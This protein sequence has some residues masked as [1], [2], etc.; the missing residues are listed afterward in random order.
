M[1]CLFPGADG[2]SSYWA[3]IRNRVDAIT[4][5]PPSHWR[6]DDYHDPD[7]RA[8]DRVYT[9]RGGFLSPVPFNPAAFGIAPKDLEAI[10]TAQLL[11]LVVAQQALADAGVGVD[12]SRTAVI[13]GVTGTLELVI[14]LGAR[15]GH[16]RWRRALREAGVA[17][18]VA[19]DVVRRIGDS[20]VGWQENS[21]PGLL[22]N[23]VA[24]RIANRFDL[25]GTNCVVDAACASSLSA[26]H[27][28]ALE[29]ATRRA[30]V[31]LT[32]GVDTFND[33]FMYMCFSKT[34]A[35]S[36]TGDARPFDAG[37]DGTILGEGLG[38]VVL[39]RL[40]DA[41]RDGDRIYAIV[42]GIGT[43]SD[44]K[45][46][47]VYAP[48][49]AG[50][51][52]ALRRA[53][54]SADISPA[55][56]ELIE[57][58]GTGTRVGDAT[59]VAALSEVYRQCGREGSWCALGSVKSQIGHTKAAAGIAG[60]L[61]A[62]AALHHKVLPPTIKVSRP[63]ENLAGGRS[64][65]YVNTENRPWMPAP[66]H[67]RRAAVSAFGFGGSNYHCVL[68]EASPT[69]ECVDWDGDVQILAFSADHPM[70]VREQFERWSADIAW[71]ELRVRAAEL[72]RAWRADRPCR[73]TIVVQRGHTDLTKVIPTIREGLLRQAEWKTPEGVYHA[74]GPEKGRLAVLFPGQGSQYVGMLRDLACTFPAM[75]DVLAE[76]NR[77]EN[78]LTDRIY[79][80]SRFTPEDRHADED[81]LRAT[82]TAQPALGAVSLGAWRVLE[83]FGVRADAMAGHSFGELTALCAAGRLTTGELHTLSRLRGR[84]M[85]TAGAGSDAGSMLAV[86]ATLEDIFRILREERLD[87]ALANKNGPMQ[88]VLSGSTPDIE[89]AAAVFAARKIQAQRLPVSAAF[90]SPLVAG[91]RQPLHDALANVAF[92]RG[93]VAVYADSTA[94]VYPDDAVAARALLAEQLARPVEFADLIEHLHRDGV[95][96]F[97]EVGPGAR[98]AGLV[99][100]ILGGQDHAALALDSSSG[101]RGGMYDL[102]RVLAW[103]AAQ[104]HSVRLDLWDPRTPP[105]SPA[106]E[107]R[108]PALVVPLCGANHVNPK[109]KP[110][111]SSPTIRAKKGSS[112]PSRNG[113]PVAKETLSMSTPPNSASPGNASSSTTGNDIALAQALEV[114]RETMAALQRMQEQTA[115]LHRQFL[116]GQESAQRSVQLLI[117]QQQRL[118]QTSLGLAPLSL[119]LSQPTPSL[120]QPTRNGQRT[121]AAPPV[122]MERTANGHVE[123]TLLSVVSEKTGYPME[124][125]D[126]DMALD[127]DL[128]IDSIK[129][130]EI[131]SALQDQ[132]PNAPNVRPEHLGTLHTLRDLAGFLGG[133]GIEP[134]AED[135]AQAQ[136]KDKPS[137]TCA[138]ASSAP[139]AEVEAILLAVVSE[140]TGYP[141]E[142][143]DLDMALDADL[144]IDSIK[145][146]EILSALQDQLPNAPNVRPEHLGTL[147]T[148]RDLAGFLGGHATNGSVTA[149]EEPR[150]AVP[151][152]ME[153]ERYVLATKPLDD[154]RQRLPIHLQEGSEIWVT[155]DDAAL[156]GLLANRMQRL[157]FR[158]IL[159]EMAA[160]TAR[161]RPS[162]LGGLVLLASQNVVTD[163]CLLDA[164]RAVQHAGPAL[165][166]GACN[167]GALLVT[168]SRLDGVFG[169][170]HLDPARE[171]IDGGLAGLVKTVARE[172]PEIHT[173]SID[174]AP[175]MDLDRAADSLLD[176]L[177]HKGPVEVG[178]SQLGPVTLDLVR[179]PLAGL[180]GPGILQPADVVVL[181]GGGR[182]V[183]AEVAVA[184]ARAFRPTLVLLGRS[185][186]SESEPDWL[187]PLHTEAEIKREL[188]SRANG[189]A[190]PRLIGEQYRQVAAQREVRRTLRRIQ[191]A[192][193]KAFYHTV[194]V[195]DRAAVAGVLGRLRHELGPVRGLIHGAGVL[196]DARI[197]DKTTDQFSAVYGTKVDGLR[198][199]LGAIAPDDL[200]LLV[201]FSSTTARLG[202]TG[203]V[204]Y[205]M[206]NEVL[207]KLGQQQA[208][209]LKGCRV[210]SINWGPWDGGM[211]TDGLK[212][213]FA[214]EGVD[215]LNPSAASEY[216]IQE[217][218]APSESAVEVVVA[219][220][221][222][223]DVISH[224]TPSGP[225]APALPIAFERVLALT[226]HTV[227]RSHVLDGR[228]VLPVVLILEWLVHAALHHNPGFTF[229]G[230]DDLRVLHGVILDGLPPRLRVSAGKAEKREEAYFAPVE[231]HGIRADGREVLHAR[232][233]VLLTT[234]LPAAPPATVPLASG[235]FVHTIEE[236]Y[237]EQLFH[238][239]ELH[240]IER[241]D[242]CDPWAISGSSRAAPSPSAW[243]RQPLRQKWLTDPLVLD[244]SFQ[245]MILWSLEQHDA[246]NL[247]C[248]VARYRQYRRQFPADGCRIAIQVTRADDRHAVADIDYLDAAG[249]IVARLEGYECILDAGL[250]RAFRRKDVER[251]S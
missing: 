198:S 209:R 53:Y 193:G 113:S 235:R 179:R 46:D 96:S 72:R 242:G 35:L 173:K 68:E 29:L 47:A 130:V 40:D 244:V 13:L 200:R 210:L 87:L 170:V 78:R 168:V 166:E 164:L 8:P 43:S 169:L 125:L 234:E 84:L 112:L 31:V 148:L 126:L 92:A 66:D 167:G 197:E 188:A 100:P 74:Q 174:L 73:L 216:L 160:V 157:G 45:G 65:C 175:E 135:R 18:E 93:L 226:D 3:N 9:A 144:G 27:L 133:E 119:P 218:D 185:P 11:G 140:K 152:R 128:G 236:M 1:A 213:V 88:T 150:S 115:Q 161:P 104:G 146:V 99:G 90:H 37:A 32:G 187:V 132:L 223:P 118:L 71:P 95:R 77:L 171:P 17:D 182:G 246:A 98:L 237:G 59:E 238:G 137:H 107:E 191:E 28:A 102:A 120:P 122:P 229:H 110:S 34:P 6:P 14:P 10:D 63:P 70:D 208:R 61:K 82:A 79:P 138:S 158:P 184:F 4:D 108:R 41:R 26:L 116:E 114:T 30:D 204:D 54:Q 159:M 214:E 212:K 75:F 25:G 221:S 134:A 149:P 19:D 109:S 250:R 194:D 227:L 91:A 21:F 38:M 42:R 36:P 44:G 33:V 20:Y 199:L 147:H 186:L 196:A 51:V 50:Q 162:H 211:V 215:L 56:I 181:S 178:L 81:A 205:A 247:P 195:C 5:V 177:F 67:P 230:C 129:R 58:H 94:E 103:L 62:V 156:A 76:A 83:S 136:T 39:K 131:L 243:M 24:G 165:R 219:A 251:L 239:P 89:R 15:L 101:K 153:I 49:A 232:A 60:L 123:G 183:T 23:V 55:T 141:M 233:E 64:P 180:T 241:I 222:L 201:L 206:A 190:A 22:G 52:E 124:M 139:V 105:S 248:H 97:L 145:R 117:E 228:P 106:T 80:I 189:S 142:M 2:L 85:A 48:K 249:L 121:P 224:A 16:P 69:K 202:R 207:N 12:R 172:W 240:G 57:A 176:E 245:M 220:G 111:P 217:I 7:P 154:G 127:A 231:L 143:L 192:G 163:A 225:S 151:P 155:A 86:L 203:Q